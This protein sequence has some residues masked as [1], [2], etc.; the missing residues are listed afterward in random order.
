MSTIA[1]FQWPVF[2][3]FT[4][5]T[6]HDFFHSSQMTSVQ[7]SS[8]GYLRYY[9]F[10]AAQSISGRRSVSSAL[11]SPKEKSS[12]PLHSPNRR[13]NRSWCEAG[14]D[15]DGWHKLVDREVYAIWPQVISR[16]NLLEQKNKQ[17]SD[18]QTGFARSLVAAAPVNLKLWSRRVSRVRKTHPSRIDSSF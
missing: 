1:L 12:A 15:G 13:C 5:K 17:I 14:T 2:W 4:S 3:R 9:W 16:I 11:G 8:F 10:I 7:H 18:W 6:L